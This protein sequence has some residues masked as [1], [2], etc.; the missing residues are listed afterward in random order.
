MRNG[1]EQ[2]ADGSPSDRNFHAIQA[3]FNFPIQTWTPSWTGSTTNPTIGNGTIA[4]LF[5][6]WGNVVYVTVNIVPGGTTTFGTG[7]YM[8]SLPVTARASIRQTLGINAY[9]V[10]VQQYVGQAI[11][12]GGTSFERILLG[13]SAT[14]PVDWSP[15]GPFTFGNADLFTLSGVYLAA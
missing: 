10:G 5:A 14:G 12:N 1:L 11:V 8:I 2:L 7:I 13:S 3:E 15:T 9:D 4:G 6:R